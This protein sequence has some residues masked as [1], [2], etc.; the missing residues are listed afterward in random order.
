MK[1]NHQNTDLTHQDSQPSK[2]P[3]ATTIRHPFC[4]T[5][6]PQPPYASLGLRP[7]DSFHSC[8][9]W[10]FT[11][12]GEEGESP[13]DPKL[14]HR[15]TWLEKQKERLRGWLQRLVRRGGLETFFGSSIPTGHHLILKRSN[16]IDDTTNN[17]SFIDE[18]IKTEIENL[19]KNLFNIRSYTLKCEENFDEISF[20]VNKREDR[21]KNKLL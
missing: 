13:N 2:P 12:C 6:K 4:D 16:M 9:G 8:D 21:D 3:G 18:K 10:T 5:S 11:A 15:A 20:V 14:S 1:Q 17:F 19:Q 7:G